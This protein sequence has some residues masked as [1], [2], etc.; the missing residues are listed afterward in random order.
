MRKTTLAILLLVL[1][2]VAGACSGSDSD[3][4]TTAGSGG[5]TETTAP[6]GDGDT[7]ETTQ[8][9]SAEPITVRAAI[10][11][12]EDTINPFSYISG[13]PGW[14]LL[15]LQYDS[16]MQLDASGIPQPWLA[17]TVTPNADLTEYTMTI[18]DG[19][20]WHDG[21]PLTINDV[22]F[23][24]DYFIANATGRFSR[25]LRGVESVEISDAG[26]LVVGLAA[27]NP[28]FDLVALADI[29]ILP[30][31]VWEG[32]D[33][34]SEQTLDIVTNVGSGPYMMTAYQQD[35][36][37][38]LAAN[39]DY[40][41]GAPNVDELVIVVFADDSGALAAIRSGEV[42]VIFDRVSPEQIALLDA[43]DPLDIAQGPEFTTQMVNFDASKAPFSDLAVRQA[44]QLAIDNQD[45]VDT[46]YL[47]SATV[48]S[49][50]WVHPDKPVYNSAVTPIYDVAAANA[51][52]D[53]AGYVDSDGDG[54][55][56]FDGQPM[57]FEMLTNSSDSLRLRISE[58]VSEM[59]GE[60]GI[61]VTVASVETATWEEAVWPGFD[62]SNGRNSEMAAGGWSAPIQ[63]NTIRIAELVNSDPGTGFLNLTGFANAEID[64][65]SA[66]LLTEADPAAAEALI[67]DLQVLI[68]EQVPFVLLAYPD[69]A[70]VYNSE[71]YAD[72]EFIAGQGIVSK[73]SLIPASGRP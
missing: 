15:M 35:Q 50:G 49:P 7:P 39:P 53:D 31:H 1:A 60:I 34:P 56:E 8:P 37:Y 51:L 12:D 42:D 6:S 14:N 28:A 63:A 72:W 4:T 30:Q 9:P 24:F 3:P 13:F 55:R 64:S 59:L 68:A 5:A 21:Q 43:Q 48:G 25:D 10:T 70:Y 23:T 57:A 27:P 65:I 29:P 41:R 66:A 58:L 62:I 44:M 61:A 2:L 26:E 22:K 40:F 46:V 32:I 17:E 19:V 71:V 69:G 18:V 38:R 36:S 33:T 52:L 47:G 16:L 45:I 11:G 20:T 54:V 67:K 73:V